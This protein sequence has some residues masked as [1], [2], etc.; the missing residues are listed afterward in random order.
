MPDA[1]ALSPL[2]RWESFYV[3]VGSSAAALT[4]L[5]FVVIA[6]VG[7][8]RA[9]GSGETIGAFATPTIVHFGAVL[10]LSAVLSAPWNRLGTAAVVLGLTGAAGV[11]YGIL[12]L[13]RARRQTGYKPVF[14]D[15]LWHT[16]FPL[17]AY[18]MVLL[19]AL[20]LVK[21]ATGGLFSVAGAALLLLFTGI[22]NAW[23]AVT[24]LTLERLRSEGH[25]SPPRED[26]TK[27]DGEP[28]PG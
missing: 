8:T 17:V 23:D 16:A 24:Y 22:H 15:W 11:V 26:G 6:V 12:V 28:P 21:H 14:E 19:A 9:P 13:M 10:W 18:A 2:L 7:E 3:I 4:G 25:E 20:G 27:R 1:H 5:Q